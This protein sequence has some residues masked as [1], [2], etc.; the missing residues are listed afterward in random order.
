MKRMYAYILFLLCVL[1]ASYPVCA[2]DPA[3]AV[4]S[5]DVDVSPATP[6]SEETPELPAPSPVA[7]K[8]VYLYSAQSEGNCSL[9]YVLEEGALSSGVEPLFTVTNTHAYISLSNVTLSAT[10]GILLSCVADQ[11]GI[12]GENGGHAQL[13]ATRQ[14]LSGDIICDE[15]SSA[16]LVLCE[17][18]TFTGAI[19]PDGAALEA[20]LFL[21]DDAVWIVTAASH[22]N[23]L[24]D[25]DETLSNIISGGF[26]VTYDAQR[27]EN[28]WLNGQCY[29]LSDG[30]QLVPFV[31]SP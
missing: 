7:A 26:T 29:T 11:W 18:A 25:E 23:V 15:I 30:G 19:N 4:S 13:L 27:E 14:L 9:Q 2:L 8:G 22:L 10:S 3:A 20:R 17:N 21:S 16:V 12:P 31:E 5:Q 28:A 1:C 24:I 6:S